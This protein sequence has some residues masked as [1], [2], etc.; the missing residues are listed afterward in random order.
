MENALLTS[1]DE[2]DSARDAVINKLTA[3]LRHLNEN[4]R[5]ALVDELLLASAMPEP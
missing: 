5:M 2:G 3:M 4:E 1:R